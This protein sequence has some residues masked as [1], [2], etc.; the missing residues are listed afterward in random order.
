MIFATE[1]SYFYD[2][3]VVD[4]YTLWHVP[5]IY[6][7]RER[8]LLRRIESPFQVHIP[9]LNKSLGGVNISL[10]GLLCECEHG[11][12]SDEKFDL[13]LVLPRMSEMICLAGSVIEEVTYNGGPAVRIRFHGLGWRSLEALSS[14]MLLRLN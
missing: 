5:D 12:L 10:A 7:P 3:T 1:P 14:W 9:E 2:Q 13:E 8:R 11:V 4:N 6:R